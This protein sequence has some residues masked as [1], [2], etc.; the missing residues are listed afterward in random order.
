MDKS[1]SKKYFIHGK[2]YT[3]HL[4]W[5]AFLKI[6]KDNNINVPKF[7]IWTDWWD[8]D[9]NNTSVTKYNKK[10]SAIENKEKIKRSINK[11]I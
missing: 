2:M 3:T 8:N 9:G 4:V 6:L 11:E 7:P 10:L 1:A 5:D